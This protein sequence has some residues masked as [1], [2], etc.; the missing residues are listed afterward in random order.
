MQFNSI[1]TLTLLV[2]MAVVAVVLMQVLNPASHLSLSSQPD[3]ISASDLDKAIK[4]HRV[5]HAEWQQDTFSGEYVKAPG[6]PP[7]HFEALVTDLNSPASTV[8]LEELKANNVNWSIDQ[9]PISNSI[10]G[11]LSVIMFPLMIIALIYFL[12][13][14]PAQ[15]NGFWAGPMNGFRSA[16]D[17]RGHC[18]LCRK[19]RDQ[20]PKLIVG[21]DGAICSDCISLCNDIL[22]H[23]PNPPKP[24]PDE[25][26]DA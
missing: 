17:R 22:Q 16:Q 6:Q 21:L 26:N 20:V 1:K 24:T 15:R 3:Q 9:P 4:E 23:E 5:L 10:L 2:I 13:L 18:A 8:L 14:R 12:V 25:P 11:A 19:S 7:R